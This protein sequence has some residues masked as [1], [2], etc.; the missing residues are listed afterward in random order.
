MK[1]S[2]SGIIILLFFAAAASA[3]DF[4][5]ALGADGQYTGDID[6]EGFSVTGSASPWISAILNGQINFYVSGKLAY[7]YAENQDPPGEFFFE[8]ERTEL[9]WRPASLFSLTLGRQRF[10]DSLGLAV[11]GLFDGAEGS[12]NLGAGRLSLGA[13]YT[14]LLYKESA[15]IIMTSA[16]A[17][18]YGKPLDA[19]DLAGY[20]ASRRVLLG[21][22]GD[23]P[24]LTPRTSLTVQGLGQFDVNDTS[25]TLHTYYLEARFRA[26]PVEP[27]HLDL[28][29]LGELL[30][31]KDEVQRSAAV[32]AGVDWEVPGLLSDLLSAK[33]LWTS[34]RTDD[35]VSAFTPV[36]GVSGGVIFDPGLR[37][38]ISAGLSYQARPLAVLSAM[39]GAAYFI[40]T[41]LETLGDGELD[42]DSDSRLLGGELYGSLVWAPDPAL[43]LNMGGGAFFPGWGGAFQEDAPVRWKVNV[44]LIVSL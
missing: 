18:N 3:L 36:G 26:E 21:L 39:A 10:R 29:A 9:N 11:S 1:K 44:G 25:N 28:G 8:L 32:S 16:D 31:G 13:F 40:R 19:E 20:F 30:Q 22:T 5:L 23:F 27:L 6:P 24:G 34:G 35:K 2:I 12:L 15:K 33:F 37:A 43:R 38:L 7:D 17:V 14:G 42:G 41:D 4:G